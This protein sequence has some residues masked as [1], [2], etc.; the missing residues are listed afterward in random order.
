MSFLGN[1]PDGPDS[2]SIGI[3][4]KNLSDF[5]NCLSD[6]RFVGHQL[7]GL[8]ST[9]HLP[10]LMLQGD[11]GPDSEGDLVYSGKF[12][13]MRKY[14]YS[15]RSMTYREIVNHISSLKYCGGIE[16]IRSSDI[17]ESAHLIANTYR[18]WTNKLYSEHRS[19]IGNHLVKAIVPD[20]KGTPV[21]LRVLRDMALQLPGVGDKTSKLVVEKFSTVENMV[22]ADW[23]DWAEI[24]GIGQKT[25]K[26]IVRVL[27]GGR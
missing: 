22:K 4:H 18:W 25:A 16:V 26:N 14:A 7:P 23:R 11:W 19:H 15:G 21:H 5:L 27:T 12:R 6:S 8:V 2:I 10:I 1:G 24:D 20:P 17:N 3:E 9:Y 13:G